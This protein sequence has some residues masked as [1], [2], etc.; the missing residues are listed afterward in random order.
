[1]CQVRLSMS[2]AV[3][4]FRN[5]TLE[6]VDGIFKWYERE[7]GQT[8]EQDVIQRIYDETRGQ[9]GLTCWLGELL[10]E[11]F[12]YYQP[13]HK[14]PISMDVFEHVYKVAI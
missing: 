13:D 12:D 4:I 2:S 5:L 6:E 3:C 8:V 10:T 1:M 14:K 11:G 7:S 9:P